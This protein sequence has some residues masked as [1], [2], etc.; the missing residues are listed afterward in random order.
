[1]KTLKTLSLLDFVGA[2]RIIVDSYMEKNNYFIYDVLRIENVEVYQVTYKLDS[3]IK[4]TIKCHFDKNN[5][6]YSIQFN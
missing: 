3:K 2:S 6:L 5:I 1:M 4:R